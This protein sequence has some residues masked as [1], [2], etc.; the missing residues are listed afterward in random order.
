MPYFM[1]GVFVGVDT[2]RVMWTGGGGV[3]LSE[4]VGRCQRWIAQCC[5]PSP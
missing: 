4:E 1:P 5:E 3:I 2:R